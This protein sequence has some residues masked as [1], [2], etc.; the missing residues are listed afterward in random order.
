MR[1]RRA[2]VSCIRK[3]EIITPE[4]HRAFAFDKR[5]WDRNYMLQFLAGG[6]ALVSL[7]ALN[8]QFSAPNESPKTPNPSWGSLTK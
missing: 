2:C 6:T 8:R 4:E 1:R 7:A 3:R 5:A